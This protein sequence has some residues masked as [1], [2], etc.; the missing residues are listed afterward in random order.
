MAVD[1]RPDAPPPRLAIEGR[2]QEFDRG[3][4]ALIA[5]TQGPVLLCQD[6]GHDLIAAGSFG[7][8]LRIVKSEALHPWGLAGLQIHRHYPARPGRPVWDIHAEDVAD[9]GA[10]LETGLLP[11]TRLVS[12]AGSALRQARLVRCQPGADLRGLVHGFVK[13][14]AHAIL[15]GSALDGHEAR[16]LG[17]RDRQA[18]AMGRSGGGQPG[19]WLTSALRRASRPVPLIP[20]AALEQSLGGALPA[21]A[22]VR[23]LSAGDRESA[24]RLGALSLVEEDLALADYVTC[25]AP[26]LSFLL[27]RMLQG[28]EAEEEG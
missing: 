2:L 14:G 28:I 9:I 8:R 13:P 10:L 17:Q 21:A 5:L 27:R 26:R 23:A 6:R 19:H 7:E 22:L 16:W 4:H 3:L 15:S 25:A 20:T 24:V 12:I 11:E 18:T 1:T